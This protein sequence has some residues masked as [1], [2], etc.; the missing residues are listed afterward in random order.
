MR[1]IKYQLILEDLNEDVFNEKFG[2]DGF[3]NEIEDE[4]IK[5][6]IEGFGISRSDKVVVMGE[7]RGNNS[8]LCKG[9][10]SEFKQWLKNEYKSKITERLIASGKLI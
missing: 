5:Y 7:I 8:S 2:D 1:F 6:G 10:L 3:W 9:L 4:D